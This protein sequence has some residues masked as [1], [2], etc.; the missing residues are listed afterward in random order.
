MEHFPSIERL[1][2]LNRFSQ[3][4]MNCE[5]I[6]EVV[7]QS[8]PVVRECLRCQVAS[9]LLFSKSGNIEPIGILGVDKDGQEINGSWIDNEF[10]YPG[11]G[12]SG[13]AIAAS[14]QDS[15]YGLPYYSNQLTKNYRL[16]Y[17]QEYVDKLGKLDRG[18][19]VPLNGLHRT[20]GTVE[21]LNTEDDRDFTQEDIIY[22]MFIGQLISNFIANVKRKHKQRVYNN[23]TE[24]LVEIEANGHIESLKSIYDYVVKELI[25]AKTSYA[26]CII[27]VD[28]GNEEFAIAAQEGIPE[29]KWDLRNNNPVNKH[30]STIVARTFN[31]Q[32]HY[33]INDL[34]LEIGNFQNPEWIKDNDLISLACFPMTALGEKVGTL[35][36]YTKFE[37]KFFDSNI[38]FLK[39]IAFL[40]ASMIA[41]SRIKQKLQKTKD[42]LREEQ[43]KMFSVSRRVGTESVLRSFLHT[44]KNELIAFGEVL[45]NLSNDSHLSVNQKQLLINQRRNWVE[46][47]I[48][49]IEQQYSHQPEALTLVNINQLIRDIIELLNYNKNIQIDQDFK[50]EIPEIEINEAKIKDVIYNIVENSMVAIKHSKNSQKGL[51]KIKTDIVK[52]SKIDQIQITIQ[53]NGKGIDNQDKERIFEKGFT[54]RSQSGGTGMGLYLAYEII[55][56]YGGKIDLEA[57]VGKGSTFIVYIP[58]KLYVPGG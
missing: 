16:K 2:E 55:T 52:M 1:N 19:S 50:D 31:E 29:I 44:Y 37:H 56:D 47:R 36:V 5:T 10:Y 22:L 3:A 43:R 25:S 23:L 58:L 8:L 15:D 33:I 45:R 9:I 27:R 28:N 54:T 13:Q 26:V 46:K 32:Q 24:K 20:F 11:E 35:S 57:Q 51:I 39:N 12:F 17:E 53:D 49:E 48:E 38:D 42:K 30:K 34:D 21:V 18:I 6:D 4:L 7:R 41:L 14:G 40:I